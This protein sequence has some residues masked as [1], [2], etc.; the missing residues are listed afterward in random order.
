MMRLSRNSALL[1]VVILAV[2]V[3]TARTSSVSAQQAPAPN[4]S[5]SLLPSAPPPPPPSALASGL[6]VTVTPYLWLAGVNASIATPL[7]RA[8]EVN[9]SV[10]AIDVL[11]HLDGAPFMSGFEIRGEPLSLLADVIHLPVSTNITT[12]NVFYNGGNATLRT[13]TGTAVLLYHVLDQPIQSL[14]AGAGVRAWGFSAGLTL[15][16]GL[17]PTVGESRSAGWA[18]PLIAARYHRELGDGFGLTAYGDVGGFG[19]GA[20][21]DWQVLGTIDYALKS[22]VAL[23]LGYRSLNFNYTAANS[24]GFNVHMRGPLLAATFRF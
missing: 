6:Q 3:A 9:A 19:L 11:G 5:P 1:A 21:V 22:W 23:R 20:H 16:G 2:M 24:I 14:D 13:N 7:P 12:R 8:S 18:D 10:S 17:Q 15:N 4:G